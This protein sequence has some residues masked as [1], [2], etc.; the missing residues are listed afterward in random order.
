MSSVTNLIITFSILE[1]EEQ[2][3]K[4]I[5]AYADGFNIV[6]VKDDKL[7]LDWYGGTKRLEC[8]VLVG[9]YNHLDL[10][11]FLNFLRQNVNWYAGDLVQLIIKE[12]EEL[13]FKLID[14]EP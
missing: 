5:S 2:I 6:S 4:Q 1:D 14:L 11:Q 13:K 12:Q 9:A 3:I 7:P 8:N 10:E